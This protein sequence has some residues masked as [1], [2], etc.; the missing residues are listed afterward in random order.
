MS[1]LNTLV[2]TIVGFLLT[3]LV[4]TWIT[5]F[6]QS[7]SW[8]HQQTYSR[9]KEKLE[10]QI[11]ITEDI[12]NLIARRKFRMLRACFALKRMNKERIEKS[13]SSYDEIVIS[14]N[15]EVNGYITKLRHYF[16]K[17]I[18]WDLD[19]HI[20]NQFRIIGEELELVKRKYEAGNIDNDFSRILVR[21]EQQLT[22]FNGETNAFVAK[23][24]DKIEHTKSDVDGNPRVSEEDHEKL[25]I[26]YLVKSLFARRELP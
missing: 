16:D 17:R 10:T 6:W 3:G 8:R 15:E 24:W 5:Y 18:Q 26:I 19:I 13:W 4:G 11:R 21:I 2:T 14:W 25:S 23:L 7:R 12:S 20:T 9:Q 1:L 22:D